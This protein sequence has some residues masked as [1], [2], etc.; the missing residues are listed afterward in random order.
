MEVENVFSGF[1]LKRKLRGGGSK[2]PL[3]QRERKR[4]SKLAAEQGLRVRGG[5][6]F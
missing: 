5:V 2:G 4:S 6:L 3:M 1:P